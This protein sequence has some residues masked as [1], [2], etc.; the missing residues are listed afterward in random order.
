MAALFRMVEVSSGRICID[1]VDISTVGLRDL[2]SRLSIVSQDPIVFTGTV[3]ENLDPAG[4]RSDAEL[5]RALKRVQ[6]VEDTGDVRFKLDMELLP[7]GSNMSAGERQLLT[8]ARAILSRAR[9]CVLDEATSAVDL[10]TDSKI[11]AVVRNEFRDKTVMIIAHRLD[12]V[13]EC[14]KILVMDGGSCV[15]LG[16]PAELALKTDGIFSHLVNETGPQAASLR[17]RAINGTWN[18]N[19]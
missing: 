19:S 11:K 16:T 12:T 9:C 4:E 2:R 13:I 7:G 5:L 8:M 18:T 3:R 14:D 1:G 15:E 17:L 6:L 10:E